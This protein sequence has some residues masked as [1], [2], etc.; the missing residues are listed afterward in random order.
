M[1]TVWEIYRLVDDSDFNSS[2]EHVRYFYYGETGQA[3]E[4]WK[5]TGGFS[6]GYGLRLALAKPEWVKQEETRYK[7]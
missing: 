3:L 4:H 2:N 6:A 5:S 7:Q 1:I